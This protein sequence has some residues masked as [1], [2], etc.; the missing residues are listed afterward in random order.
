VARVPRSLKVSSSLRKQL[1]LYFSHVGTSGPLSTIDFALALLRINTEESLRAAE[2]ITGLTI[3]V[4]PSGLPPWPPKEAA[5]QRSPVLVRIERNPCLP[6]T[7]AFQRYRKLRIGMT[8]EQLVA[9]GVTKRDLRLWARA[10]RIR[11]Q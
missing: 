6:T 2:S 4:Y 10:G 3:K 9:R 7:D 5:V 1:E 11:F 8:A